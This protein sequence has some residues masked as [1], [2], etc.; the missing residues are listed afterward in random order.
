MRRIFLFVCLSFQIF[1]QTQRIIALRVAF[2]ADQSEFTT[3]NGLF[4]FRS[5]MPADS[6]Q[7]IVIDPP[8]HNRS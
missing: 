5:D 7:S 6:I 2:K 4:D 8:P 1:G 3:G